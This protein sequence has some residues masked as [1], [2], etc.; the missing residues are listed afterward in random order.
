LSAV[1]PE[2]RESNETVLRL[3]SLAVEMAD[4]SSARRAG[5]NT[6][7]LALQTGL[8]A[9]LGTYA[10]RTGRAG[11]QTDRFVLALAVLAGLILA[12]AWLFLLR[13]YRKLNAAKFTVIN[14]MERMYFKVRPF[15]DEWALLRQDHLV[16]KNWRERV[17]RRRDRYAELG[18]VER[19][20]PLAFVVL[21]VALGAHV[22]DWW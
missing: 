16:P 3:Y 22:L 13:S 7:F 19:V 18:V 1:A 15:T 4:R 17:S 5:A 2:A 6:F 12:L 20:V 21:Y 9:L 14:E 10:V 11:E 8:A